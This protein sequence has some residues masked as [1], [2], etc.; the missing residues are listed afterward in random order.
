MVNIG[1]EA[2]G[3]TIMKRYPKRPEILRRYAQDIL[4][5]AKAYTVPVP[6]DKVA[7]HLGISVNYEPF[8]GELSGMIAKKGQHAV[9]GVNSL[10][11]NNRQRF[12]LAHEIGHY[13]LHDFDVHVDKSFVVRNRDSKS[14][15][16]IDHEE[17]E[18]N[19]FAAELLMPKDL[20]EADLDK[21]EIDIED[22]ET[23]Q[24]MARRYG[25]SEQAM[26]L[27]IVNLVR[28]G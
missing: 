28:L 27:R 22:A 3:E 16:A 10:Q 7:K 9:I 14:S 24:H 18:A 6:L 8:D 5:R 2:H 12:T 19:R 1:D 4:R 13:A 26:T 21:F 11:S 17:I 23:I 25:V 15:L 20:L